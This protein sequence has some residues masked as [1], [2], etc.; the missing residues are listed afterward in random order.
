M[1]EYWRQRY[2]WAEVSRRKLMALA[3]DWQTKAEG[4][5]VEVDDLKA[6]HQNTLDHYGKQA[7]E[8]YALKLHVSQLEEQLEL[9]GQR[10]QALVDQGRQ[11]KE[12][13]RMVVDALRWGST[14]T[15]EAEAQAHPTLPQHRQLC[16][17]LVTAV[18]NQHTRGF[19]FLNGAKVYDVETWVGV[20]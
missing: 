4:A 8:N 19:E 18:W 10:I 14:P 11:E 1:T 20:E 16:S 5:L 6:L 7:Q 17:V 3:L 2:E 9:C 15:E 13:L 12:L